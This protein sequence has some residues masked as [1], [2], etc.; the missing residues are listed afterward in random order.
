M[1]WAILA[2]AR[3]RPAVAEFGAPLPVRAYPLHPEQPA[4][5]IHFEWRHPQDGWTRFV[6]EVSQYPG[7]EYYE[8]LLLPAHDTRPWGP[9]WCGNEP[10]D[11]PAVGWRIVDGDGLVV[12]EFDGAFAVDAVPLARL[13]GEMRWYRTA[14]RDPACAPTAAHECWTALE[15]WI[16]LEDWQDE[17]CPSDEADAP[18]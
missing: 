8:S 3:D 1:L 10:P 5:D 13:L 16:F 11:P 2:A 18:P 7:F 9:R 6:L 15:L 14:R 12:T 4:C 17:H